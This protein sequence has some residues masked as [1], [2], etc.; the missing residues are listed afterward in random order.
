MD[1]DYGYYIVFY[2]LIVFA[3]N[4]QIRF[5]SKGEFNLP[6]GK[7]DF[8]RSMQKKLHTFINR[9]D[10]INCAFS[11]IDFK[12]FDIAKLS[13]KDFVYCDPP[14]LIACASYNEQGGWNEK[15]EKRLY[16]MVDNL[17]KN[18]I[19]FVLSSVL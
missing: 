9:L 13:K 11:C 2:V 18:N 14:Y 17:N 10:E 15:N 12:D 3:F 8:N 1:E 4:N 5:N 7:R 16:E 19:R 6:V